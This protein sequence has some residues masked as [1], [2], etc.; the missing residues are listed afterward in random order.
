MIKIFRFSNTPVRDTPTILFFPV[1]DDQLLAMLF[2]HHLLTL[3]PSELGN[4]LLRDRE[5]ETAPLPSHAREL[6]DILI[7]QFPSRHMVSIT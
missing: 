4:E 7:L 5:S 6:P 2:H 1:F 3:L